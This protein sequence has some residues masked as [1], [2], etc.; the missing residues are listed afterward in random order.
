MFN[1]LT[2]ITCFD[3]KALIP[4]TIIAPKSLNAINRKHEIEEIMRNN[5]KMFNT[6]KNVKPTISRKDWTNFSGSKFFYISTSL[7]ISLNVNGY[8]L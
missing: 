1:R 6:L 7:H 8:A 3:K 4:D 5:V 2:K